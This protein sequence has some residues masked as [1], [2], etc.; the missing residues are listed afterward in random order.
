MPCLSNGA[1]THSHVLVIKMPALLGTSLNHVAGLASVWYW[2]L[3]RAEFSMGYDRMEFRLMEYKLTTEV[4]PDS[5]TV[6]DIA[7]RKR[8]AEQGLEKWRPRFGGAMQPFQYLV[9]VC[10]PGNLTI[11]D[12]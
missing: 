1:S 4:M 7:A 6:P 10:K 11:S 12:M 5:R 3:E 8:A 2:N 9:L